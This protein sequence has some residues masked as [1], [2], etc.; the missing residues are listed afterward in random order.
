[1]PAT[2][3]AGSVRHSTARLSASTAHQAAVERAAAGKAGGLEA[4]QG[5]RRQGKDRQRHQHF[6]Q[7]E[8]GFDRAARA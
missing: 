1:M 6:E 5:Q 7:G 8:T 3:G 4:Q 2:G